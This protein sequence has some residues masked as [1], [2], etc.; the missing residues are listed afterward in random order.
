MARWS[1]D[2]ETPGAGCP[3][4]DRFIYLTIAGPPLMVLILSVVY[5]LLRN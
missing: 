1:H 5:A 4:C 2:H 3:A